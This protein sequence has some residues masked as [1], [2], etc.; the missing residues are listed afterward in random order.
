ME[1]KKILIMSGYSEFEYAKTAIKIGVVDYLLKPVNLGELSKILERSV[2]EIQEETERE[3]R[4]SQEILQS[5]LLGKESPGA[6]LGKLLK[7]E[8]V[9]GEIACGLIQGDL[10][11]EVPHE[12][13]TVEKLESEDMDRNH[14]IFQQIDERRVL[15]LLNLKDSLER[16]TYQ[17]VFAS[18]SRQ[19]NKRS[20]ASF[21][22]GVS[23]IGMFE[24]LGSLY[25]QAERALKHRMYLGG[26][27]CIFYEMLPAS[28]KAGAA[29]YLDRR[30]F[31]EQ[32][33]L[34]HIEEVQHIIH[35]GFSLL[36]E[37]RCTEEQ[38]ALEL[39]I[40]V[41]N[42]LVEAMHEKGVDIQSLLEKNSTMFEKNVRYDTFES[43]EKW[44]QDYCGLLLKGLTD[45]SQKKHSIAVAKA[46]DYINQHYSEEITLS[47]LAE[48]ASKSTNYFSFVFKKEVGMNFNEYLNEVRIRKAKEILDTTD[49]MIYEVAE[50]VGYN[51]YKY[52]T[53][54]FKKICGC[55]PSE[56]KEKR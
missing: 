14:Q 27:N 42:A 15:V 23:R 37:A 35:D 4:L 1:Q 11:Y 41:K 49:N 53:K 9:R 29:F 43:Y 50:R 12:E 18:I 32:A 19:I 13:V 55:S 24:E 34:F 25:A 54:V 48:T 5:V 51:D 44:C 31:K 45:L 22:M 21:S 39:C 28:E 6:L 16:N 52:F 26:G 7:E 33:S 38:K 17:S 30:A 20:S 47:F 56:Y 2:K 3:K 36:C 8:D 10:L 40:S 46:V